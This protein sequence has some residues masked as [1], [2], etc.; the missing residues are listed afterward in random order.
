MDL[1]R[2]LYVSSA[3]A[4]GALARPL[5]LLQWLERHRRSRTCLYLRSLFSIYDAE[6]LLR[7][8]LPW[9]SFR[10]I[11]FLEAVVEARG[12]R[13]TVFE[14]GSGA[15]TVWLARRCNAVYSVE[16]DPDWIDTARRL[17]SANA[18]VD[19]SFVPATPVL[20][21]TRCR[22]ERSGWTHL[23]FDRYVES[24]RAYPFDFDLIVIDGRCRAECLPEAERKLKPGGLILFDDSNRPRYRRAIEHSSLQK[25]VFSG[26]VPGLPFPGETT[27]LHAPG[28]PSGNR[29]AEA[30][31]GTD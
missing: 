3:R 10:A 5:G 15:S 23:S 30:E 7:L 14:Y 24:I 25:Q 28:A 12:H 22:S 16:H 6:D 13:M 1:T 18:N 11:D 9:W 29:G 2:T 21:D 4:L 26:L 20:A 31:E 17:C 8:D 27:I 19:L